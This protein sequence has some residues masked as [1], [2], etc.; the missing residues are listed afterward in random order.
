[1]IYVLGVYDTTLLLLVWNN[2][3]ADKNNVILFFWGF[4]FK[5]GPK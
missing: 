2:E 5:N 3:F 1:M 4:T